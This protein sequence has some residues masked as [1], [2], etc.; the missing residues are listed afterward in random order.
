MDEPCYRY[1]SLVHEGQLSAVG[2]GTRWHIRVARWTRECGYVSYLAGVSERISGQLLNQL[3]QRRAEL[4][5]LHG[6]ES[7][8]DEYRRRRQP[9]LSTGPNAYARVSSRA[10]RCRM[11][12]RTRWRT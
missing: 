4:H 8:A 7:Y 3:W 2:G 11:A 5:A 10:A 1:G 6:K 12:W 9:A